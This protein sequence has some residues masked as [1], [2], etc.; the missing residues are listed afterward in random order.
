MLVCVSTCT[1][2]KVPAA[3]VGSERLSCS[4]RRSQSVAMKASMVAML[5]SIIPAPLQTPAMVAP[6]CCAQ[7]SLG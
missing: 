6:A 4:A 2:L 5:G 3:M 7:A 1:A